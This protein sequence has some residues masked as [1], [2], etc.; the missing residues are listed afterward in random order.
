MKL[1]LSISNS[2]FVKL[3]SMLCQSILSKH[4]KLFCLFQIC[5]M[6]IF[7]FLISFQHN[8]LLIKRFKIFYYNC[9]WWSV[10]WIFISLQL[11]L[12][13]AFGKITLGEI[14]RVL[15]DFEKVGSLW[16]LV[17]FD[18][19]ITVEH[20]MINTEYWILFGNRNA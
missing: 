1:S 4:S 6:Y 10:W 3:L 12:T 2:F 11:N 18:N 17:V 13:C 9:V 5:T 19:G 16:S 20:I 15:C 14:F 7:K 8:L